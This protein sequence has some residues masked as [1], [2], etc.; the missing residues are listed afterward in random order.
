M[1]KFQTSKLRL[2]G[3]A[4]ACALLMLCGALFGTLENK[5]A[6]ATMT[7]TST[8]T[9][10][11]GDLFNDTSNKFNATVLNNLVTKLGGTTSGTPTANVNSLKSNVLTSQA[12]RGKNSGNDVLVNFGGKLWNVTYVSQSKTGDVIATLW[13]AGATENS[14]FSSGW[15]TQYYNDPAKGYNMADFPYYSNQYGSSFIRSVTLNAGSPYTKGHNYIDGDHWTTDPTEVSIVQPKQSADNTWSRFTMSATDLKAA[16]KTGAAANSL[17]AYIATP[18]EISWQEDQ[19]NIVHMSPNHTYNYQNEHY[20]VPAKENWYVNL[21]ATGTENRDMSQARFK[22]YYNDWANDYIWL[23]SLTETGYYD[24]NSDGT[25]GRDY[26]GIWA[27]SD[28][29]R[30]N[31]S[32]VTYT[33]QRSGSHID[34]HSAYMLSSGGSRAWSHV[35]GS[36]A[37]R[38]ALHLN[39]SSAALSAAATGTTTGKEIVKKPV[40]VNTT[41]VYTNDKIAFDVTNIDTEFVKMPTSLTSAPTGAVA[42]KIQ[43]TQVLVQTAGNYSITL[44]LK[45]TATSVWQD[46]TTGAIVINFKVTKAPITLDWGTDR[47]YEYD[48]AEHKPTGTGYLIGSTSAVQLD[49][50]YKYRKVGATGSLTAL[51]SG[52]TPKNAGDYQITAQFKNAADGVNYEIKNPSVDFTIAQQIIEVDWSSGTAFTYNKTAQAPAPTVK[53]AKNA[54]VACTLTYF[55]QQSDGTFP[56]TGS[57]TKPSAAGNYNMTVVATADADK[58]N[59]KLVNASRKFDIAQKTVTLKG[60]A[61][62]DKYYDGTKTVVWTGTAALDGIITGD[63]VTLKNSGTDAFD[64][65]EVGLRY[66]TVSGYS[67]DGTDKDNYKLVTS[68]IKLY[69]NILK[70]PVYVSGISVD[71]GKKPYDGTTKATL[72]YTGISLVPSTDVAITSIGY[73]NDMATKLATEIAG[74]KATLSGRFATADAGTDIAVSIDNIIIS[75]S[76]TDDFAKHFDLYFDYTVSKNTVKADIEANTVTVTLNIADF[77]YGENVKVTYTVAGVPATETITV[78]LKYK[79]RGTTVYAESATAPTKAGTYTVTASIANGNYD[80]GATTKDYEIKKKALTITADN[81]TV[82]YGDAAPAYTASY[83]GFI[84]GEDQTT[85]GLFSGTLTYTAQLSSTEYAAGKGVGSYVITPSG[86]T[87]DNY[88][89]TFAAG[90]LT[91]EKKAVVI[92]LNSISQTY[93]G[94][95]DVELDPDATDYTASDVYSFINGTGVYGSDVLKIKVGAPANANV[96]KTILKAASSLAS[97][98]PN[99]D[100]TC[101]DGLYEITKA[102]LTVTAADKTVEYGKE[103]K[104]CS[105]GVTYSG[106]VTGENESTI[107]GFGTP[108]YRYTYTQYGDVFE[109]D[110]TTKIEYAIIPGG[111]TA[112][113]YDIVYKNGKLTIN[114]KAVTVEINHVT[115]TYGDT[116][117]RLTYGV[118]SGS[119][120]VNG[121][122]LGVKLEVQKADGTKVTTF[123]AGTYKIVATS[124]TNKNYAVTFEGASKPTQTY[125]DYTVNKATLKVTAK[126]HSIVYGDAAANNGYEI[127]GF[128]NGETDSVVTSTSAVTY[129]YDYNTSVAGSREVGTYNII[130]DVSGLSALNYNITAVN[131]KLKVEKKQIEIDIKNQSVSYTGTKPAGGWFDGMTNTWAL[132]TGSTLATW[133]ALTDIGVTLTRGRDTETGVGAYIITGST[134]ANSNYDIIVNNGT[135]TITPFEITVYWTENFDNALN[136]TSYV[137]PSFSFTYNGKSQIP[138]AQ[139]KGANGNWSQLSTSGARTNAGTTYQAEAYLPDTVNYTFAA[140]TDSTCKFT[141]D[142]REL[143]IAWLDKSGTTH[144][145]LTSGNDFVFD[146]L[147]GTPQ[148]P[149]VNLTNTAAGDTLVAGTDYYVEGKNSSTGTWTA[150]L[151]I[152]N[153]NYKIATS[154]ATCVYKVQKAAPSGFGWYES[155][156]VTPTA[157]NKLNAAVDYIFNGNAQHPVVKSGPSNSD[158]YV[159]TFYAFNSATNGWDKLG[160]DAPVNAGK[161]KVEATPVSGDY[162]VD[163]T[164]A[165]T[166]GYAEFTI[167]PKEITLNWNFGG[168]ATD[169]Y[170]LEYNGAV[171]NPVVK[172]E[173]STG[174]FLELAVQVYSDSACTTVATSKDAG[175]Y[176]V[177]T[178]LPSNGNYAFSGNKFELVQEYKITAK[179]IEVEW[180]FDSSEW[181]EAS[182]E[183]STTYSAKALENFVSKTATMNNLVGA[184][185]VK[186]VYKIYRV[187]GGKKTEVTQI[188]DAGIYTLAVEFDGTNSAYKNYKLAGAEQQCTVDKIDLT[189]TPSNMTVNYGDTLK[190]YEVTDGSFSGLLSSEESNIIAALTNTVD[191]KKYA[192]G[193]LSS[194]YTTST[195]PGSV[196]IVKTTSASELEKLNQIL[197]NYNFNILAATLVIDARTGDVKLIGETTANGDFVYDGKAHVP[198][199]S[200]KIVDGS[201]EQWI[202]L[203]VI[204]ITDPAVNA[205]LTDGEAINAGKYKIRVERKDGDNHTGVTLTKTEFEFDILKR[206]I[207]VELADRE[208]YYGEVS[209]S[210]YQSKLSVEYARQSLRPLAGDDLKIKATVNF[211]TT[212][213]DAG[214]F[215]TANFNSKTEKY[216]KDYRIQ[217]SWDSATYGSNYNVVFVGS[218]EDADGAHTEGLFTVKT[219]TITVLKRGTELFNEEGVLDSYSSFFINLDTQRDGK[220]VFINFDG[221]ADADVKILYSNPYPVADEFNRNPE[222]N[223]TTKPAIV[224]AG[225]WIV[226]YKISIAN[227]DDLEGKWYVRI[228]DRDKYIIVVFQKDFEISYGDELPENLAEKLV[229]EGYV[230]VNGAMQAADFKKSAKAYAFN[231]SQSNVDSTTN[232]GKY[233]IYF[234]LNE[235]VPSNNQIIYKQS[236]AD[237][238]SNVGRYVI[239]KRQLSITW[240]DTEF[241]ADGNVH[242]PVPVISGWIGDDL[243]LEGIQPNETKHYND[244]TDGGKTIR[245]SVTAEGDFVRIGG[246]ELTVTVDNDN[247]EISGK[248]A[249]AISIVAPDDIVGGTSIPM[250]VWYVVGAV[251]AV[252]ILLIVV[253]AVKLKKRR[254][255]EDLDGFNDIV[256]SE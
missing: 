89:I 132:H 221:Y 158:K 250:W 185:N 218:Q 19:T 242:M 244:F 236:N 213:I 172:F 129:T 99:Y 86:L 34:P 41:A 82:T 5:S 52:E 239:N 212:D 153:P 169:G 103:G 211:A 142:K 151:I 57:T 193:W 181:T 60:L 42:A 53:N 214:N 192:N 118:K 4:L 147:A 173:V 120:V 38:P 54:A 75:N 1:K 133:D 36:R 111:L 24:K 32:D 143:T 114:P 125:G 74:L 251:A 232:V 47:R 35:Q 134:T 159:Y 17:T 37:V 227:H 58:N 101:L 44:T 70:T 145:D 208:F 148:A 28:Q 146:F 79:G 30:S 163:V 7:S 206:E 92:Q 90:T 160:N 216:S 253:L 223:L 220:Y 141:I 22:K 170:T 190:G 201:T 59:Y 171:Q 113:N 50:S 61:A 203:D 233:T 45:D 230:T 182:G 71:G 51:A 231:G 234:E 177:K 164:V 116:P 238:D 56:T 254:A 55:K 26:I 176:Y 10:T 87:A 39:L 198:T 40:M 215:I 204:L 108:S 199:A 81:K 64:S 6:S 31:S 209:T 162:T 110:G 48:G 195:T 219:S 144:T 102:T 249:K 156:S 123:D 157:G 98:N 16:G 126:D 245:V 150:T 14:T 104:D 188:K 69:A 115:E 105:P 15:L 186:L 8:T 119:S 62:G 174:T 84:D 112:A 243:S 183:V 49:Y 135:Y 252:A 225:E 43:N 127:T 117:A 80:L 217:G 23:P 237:A 78:T 240:G 140:T 139:Y 149:T 138:V 88:D 167:K 85:A 241:T 228:L 248:S 3:L 18:S 165:Y 109:A 191:G 179:V 247:Y 205:G 166:G 46:G 77:F 202:A 72:K 131:G 121:D 12:I 235:D 155:E 97:D 67:L 178:T 68:D 184:D 95:L 246:H 29:Q 2:I 25:R 137:K 13:Y 20:G 130:P 65:A 207:T 187:D 226:N 229:D 100:I 122:D 161:Y 154:G 93:S 106:F 136:E 66:V 21:T 180:D 83:D 210:N 91:V 63:A 197:R 96:G 27:T 128:V 256:D 224:T 168:N 11:G 175:T 94:K 9:V 200:Y 152:I 189:I 194:P 76:G 255:V 33:W 124:W 107:S 73:A 196:S 222:I